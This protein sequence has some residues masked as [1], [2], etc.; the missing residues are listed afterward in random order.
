VLQTVVRGG[1]GLTGECRKSWAATSLARC[2]CSNADESEG[3]VLNWGGDERVSARMRNSQRQPALSMNRAGS[4]QGTRC[5]APAN[6]PRPVHNG[7]R[8]LRHRR[9]WE[10]T[11]E[12]S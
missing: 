3:V 7:A 4:D 5:F 2:K 10:D 8:A 6:D 11:R 9:L 12:R 1:E